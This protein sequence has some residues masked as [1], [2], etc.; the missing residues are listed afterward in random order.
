MVFSGSVATTYLYMFGTL[1]LIQRVT[2]LLNLYV[3]N[4]K[5][6][7][8]YSHTAHTHTHERSNVILE[9]RVVNGGDSV[10]K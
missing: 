3:K 7:T 9:V 2:Y 4:T 6:F 10:N 8:K 1:N 5:Y